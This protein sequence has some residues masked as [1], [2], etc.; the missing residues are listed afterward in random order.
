MGRDGMAPDDPIGTVRAGQGVLAVRAQCAQP[1]Y[2]DDLSWFAIDIG[3]MGDMP[4]D[5]VE[6]QIGTWPIVYQP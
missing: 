4:P 3:G 1:D 2:E 6:E 5:E